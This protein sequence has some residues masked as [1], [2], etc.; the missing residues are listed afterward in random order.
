M[1]LFANYRRF[2]CLRHQGSWSKSQPFPGRVTATA[3]ARHPIRVEATWQLQ[4]PRLRWCGPTATRR[5]VSGGRAPRGS[6]RLAAHGS[7]HLDA[8]L[9]IDDGADAL[10]ITDHRVGRCAEVHE[11]RSFFS[12][13][14]SPL[15]VTVKVPPVCPAA[16]S[17]WH[18][19]PVVAASLR[20]IGGLLTG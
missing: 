12:F 9:V 6:A 18:C 8:T 4:R 10:S 17:G 2:A 11:E 16:M 3:I 19:G 5:V 15:R 20:G 1:V 13:T 14:V 7:G